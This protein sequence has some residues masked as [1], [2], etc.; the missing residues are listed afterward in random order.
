MEKVKTICPH[1]NNEIYVSLMLFL[2]KNKHEVE[3]IQE[4]NDRCP[5][6]DMEG[7]MFEWGNSDGTKGMVCGNCGWRNI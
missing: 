5:K 6:C 2:K 7:T 1:C 3:S 4:S